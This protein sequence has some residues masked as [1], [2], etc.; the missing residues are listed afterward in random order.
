M[1]WTEHSASY[2]K[3]NKIDKAMEVKKMFDYPPQQR[4]LKTVTIG[5]DVYMAI[6]I[7]K[8]NQIKIIPTVC[9]FR[10]VNNKRGSY[11]C[12]ETYYEGYNFPES[13]LK[14]IQANDDIALMEWKAQQLKF[15]AEKKQKVKLENGDKVIF[16]N[17]S[18]GGENEWIYS[19]KY[20][21]SHLFYNTKYGYKKLKGWTK[22]DY[23][24]IKKTA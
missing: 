1:G 3:G 18:F 20:N 8:N 13:L 15:L 21:G 2:Y 5:T 9:R 6:E 12:K 24:I 7:N 16:T 22:A 4:V 17:S 23:E 14:L 11:E 10:A 19:G